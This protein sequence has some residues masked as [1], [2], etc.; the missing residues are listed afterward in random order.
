MNHNLLVAESIE[1]G[2]LI[3]E[4]IRQELLGMIRLLSPLQQEV[5]SRRI[6]NVE[7]TNDIASSLGKTPQAISMLLN[8]AYHH[9]RSLLL[10]RGFDEEEM[11]Y[12]LALLANTPPDLYLASIS[13][14]ES[15]DFIF[16]IR[17]NY[18][19]NFARG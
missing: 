8:R 12:C 4:E 16:F 9:L 10:R 18:P 3:R 2:N 6:Y 15:V 13:N 19:L 1:A 5:L 11:K 7:A 17:E 14:D